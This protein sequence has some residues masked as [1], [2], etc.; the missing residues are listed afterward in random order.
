MSEF[1]R[2]TDVKDSNK[3]TA[4]ERQ[5]FREISLPR[6]RSEIMDESAFKAEIGRYATA[7]KTLS[8]CLKK[9]HDENVIVLIDEY[10][11]NSQQGNS[12]HLQEPDKH[13]V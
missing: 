8:V 12:E 2:H 1:S 9:Y 10:D 7:L 13:M 4:E 5:A 3:L 11:A 6:K